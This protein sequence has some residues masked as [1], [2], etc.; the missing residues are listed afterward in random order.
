[1]LLKLY[2]KGLTQE[3]LSKP[4]LESHFFVLHWNLEGSGTHE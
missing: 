1:M 4:A 3:I 2:V